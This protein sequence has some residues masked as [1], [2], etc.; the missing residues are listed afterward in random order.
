MSTS[1]FFS[2]ASRPVNRTVGCPAD[3]LRL[4]YPDHFKD[5]LSRLPDGRPWTNVYIPADVLG[6]NFRLDGNDIDTAIPPDQQVE[7][8]DEDNMEEIDEENIMGRR[9]RGRNID[10]AEA[11]K[12]LEVDDE[13]EE[14]D[15]DFVDEEDKME[16]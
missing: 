5:R 12:N 3:F 1:T 14:E 2:T 6:S 15:E 7:E 9:T 13:D 16:E 4:L 11:D 8:A 10:F